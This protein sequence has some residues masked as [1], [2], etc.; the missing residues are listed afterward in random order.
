MCYYEEEKKKKKGCHA[1]EKAQCPED[2]PIVEKYCHWRHLISPCKRTAPYH[3]LLQ[4]E[5]LLKEH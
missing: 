5:L 4:S 2:F 1:T 3:Q